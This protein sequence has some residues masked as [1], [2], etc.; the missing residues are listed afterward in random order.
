MTLFLF[1]QQFLQMLQGDEEEHAVLLLNY[2]LHLGKRAW[3]ILGECC[4]QCPRVPNFV[5]PPSEKERNPNCF[6][7]QRAALLHQGVVEWP[8]AVVS[9]TPPPLTHTIVRNRKIAASVN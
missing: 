2:F 4:I 3:L 1:L 6:S 9:T 5:S 8:Q 7:N